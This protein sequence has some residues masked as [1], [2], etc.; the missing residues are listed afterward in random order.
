MTWKNTA[1][2]LPKVR[3]ASFCSK[4]VLVYTGGFSM[5][6]ARLWASGQWRTPCETQV[7]GDVRAWRKLP[8]TPE[9]S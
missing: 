4:Y 3:K 5:Q 7:N 6:T 1:H 2:E 8:D 9:F